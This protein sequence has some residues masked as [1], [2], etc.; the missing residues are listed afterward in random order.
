MN[1]VEPT[2][3]SDIN[4]NNAA[5]NRVESLVHPECNSM[6]RRQDLAKVVARSGRGN[7]IKQKVNFLPEIMQ[8]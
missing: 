2:D 7:Y 6:S 4:V 3:F 8:K 1:T 5:V